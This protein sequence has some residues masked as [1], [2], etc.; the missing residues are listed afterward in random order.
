MK[1]PGSLLQPAL[2]GISLLAVVAAPVEAGTE[3][4]GLFVEFRATRDQE[5]VPAKLQTKQMCPN[6]RGRHRFTPNLRVEGENEM[7]IT[8]TFIGFEFTMTLT[9]SGT[10]PTLRKTAEYRVTRRG[11]RPIAGG[12]RRIKVYLEA[13][14]CVRLTFRPQTDLFLLTGEVVTASL[15]LTREPAP[16]EPVPDTLRDVIEALFLGSGPLEQRDDQITCP[17]EPGVW[18][19]FPRGTPI[20]V[21]VSTT[22]SADKLRAIRNAAAQVATATNDE[23]TATVEIVDE[24]NPFPGNDEV[25][26]TTHP[27]PVTEGCPSNNGCTMFRFR[28]PGV[29]FWSRA[30]Q[31]ANQTP[32]AYAHDAIGHGVMGMCHIDGFRNGGPG[33]SLMSGG[34]SVFSGDIALQLTELDIQAAQAVYASSLNPGASR[35]DFVAAGLINP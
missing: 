31:P 7:V 22:V 14:D 35:A 21:L 9:R 16:P 30:V 5:E 27:S 13:G 26:S 2:A 32:N 11:T 25:T 17:F 29:L 15:F 33:R 12:A 4:S 20:R 24:D 6:R 8:N 19:G 3:T 28:S 23:I 10:Q 34:P 1:S 18:S